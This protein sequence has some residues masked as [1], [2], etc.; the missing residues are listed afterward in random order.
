MAPLAWT[1]LVETTR[2]RTPG[3][4]RPVLLCSLGATTLIVGGYQFQRSWQG[5]GGYPWAHRAVVVGW[6]LKLMWTS[7]LAVSAYWAHPAILLRLPASEIAWMAVSPV[8]LIVTVIGA[9]KTIRRLDMSRRLLRFQSHTT[10]AAAFGF[11]LFVFGT[12]MWLVDGGAGPADLFQAGTVDLVGLT[13]MTAALS[14]AVRA[15]QRTA[16]SPSF[17]AV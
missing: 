2:R 10:K 4:L 6:M 16:V 7:T 5:T 14:V 15:A 8:A 3:L 17:T 11:G 9:A 1:V 13:V 12:L